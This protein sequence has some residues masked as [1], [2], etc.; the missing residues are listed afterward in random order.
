MTL[1]EGRSYIGWSLFGVF[2]LYNLFTIYDTGYLCQV[3]DDLLGR[4]K[5]SHNITFLRWEKNYSQEQYM[6]S[7]LKLA[8]DVTLFTRG[9]IDYRVDLDK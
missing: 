5:K 1:A 8:V 9:V 3:N 6:T 2:Y 4:L 7:Q